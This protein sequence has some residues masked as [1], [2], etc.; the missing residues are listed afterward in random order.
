MSEIFEDDLFEDEDNIDESSPTK[1]NCDDDTQHVLDLMNKALNLFQQAASN[2]NNI[3]EIN[4]AVGSENTG[5][6]TESLITM[7][8]VFEEMLPDLVLGNKE[9][10]MLSMAIDILGSEK[11]AKTYLEEKRLAILER[12]DD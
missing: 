2:F 11:L 1:V 8:L 10:Y 7:K 3:I 4:K 6:P 12:I 9:E 5:I